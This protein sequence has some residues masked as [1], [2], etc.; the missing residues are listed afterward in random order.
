M[1]GIALCRVL[2]P[3]NVRMTI[4]ALHPRIREHQVLMTIPAPDLRM[5]AAQR[6]SSFLVI[7]FRNRPD[8]LPSLRRVA[9][10]ARN[11]ELAVRAVRVVFRRARL[12]FSRS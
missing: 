8:R 7:K 4:L 3:V 10:L 1:A 5:Q 11:R 2:A 9:V 6:K 12:L